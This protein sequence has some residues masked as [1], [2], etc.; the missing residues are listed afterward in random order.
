MG[1]DDDDDD[2][3]DD[4]RLEYPRYAAFDDVVAVPLVA[5]FE[6][7]RRRQQEHADDEALVLFANNDARQFANLVSRR[8]IDFRAL[9]AAGAE[10]RTASAPVV[11]AYRVP[12]TLRERGRVD[13][14]FEFAW[15]DGECFT[16]FEALTRKPVARVRVRVRESETR[17]SGRVTVALE[18]VYS[19]CAASV[20]GRGTS[21]Q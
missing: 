20:L 6:W 2:D 5:Y 17:S 4:E 19:E 10:V 8:A 1:G 7:P 18:H 15:N 16:L 21:T 12:R 11:L 9:V 3:K 14:A 13:D